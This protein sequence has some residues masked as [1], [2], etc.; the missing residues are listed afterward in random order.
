MMFISTTST[1]NAEPLVSVN[2]NEI[3]VSTQTGDPVYAQIIGDSN[4]EFNQELSSLPNGIFNSAT[5]ATCSAS[6]ILNIDINDSS[7]AT[8]KITDSSRNETFVSVRND[9]ENI[10]KNVLWKETF[11]NVINEYNLDSNGMAA[12][13]PAYPATFVSNFY[14]PQT[15]TIQDITGN[16]PTSTYPNPYLPTEGISSD[17][18][19]GGSGNDSSNVAMVIPISGNKN[20]PTST[21]FSLANKLYNYLENDKNYSISFD[22]MR[23]N[24]KISPSDDLLSTLQIVKNKTEV[25]CTQSLT[26]IISW[27][28]LK[29]CSFKYHSGDEIGFRV[30]YPELTNSLLDK[31]AFGLIVDNIEISSL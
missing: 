20:Q 4:V 30:S 5:L 18:L 24:I 7:D 26:D 2:S 10:S 19:H 6:C 25:I 12:L 9:E 11:D 8:V 17:I 1:A 14:V 21:T 23:S 22:I 15:V 31:S 27:E 28:K 29:S 16:N 3:M 13:L